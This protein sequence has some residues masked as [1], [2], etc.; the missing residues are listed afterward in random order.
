[1]PNASISAFQVPSRVPDFEK[2]PG[3]RQEAA[4][5]SAPLLPALSPLPT[6]V[7]GNFLPTEKSP[8]RAEFPLSGVV[9]CSQ[10]THTLYLVCPKTSLRHSVGQRHLLRSNHDSL[11]GATTIMVRSDARDQQPTRVAALKLQ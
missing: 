5:P 7:R 10:S 6:S 2:V 9:R 8:S 1:M 3:R 11:E 4:T